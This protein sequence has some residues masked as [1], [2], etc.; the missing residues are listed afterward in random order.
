MKK[1]QIENIISYLKQQEKN[2]EELKIG[3]EFEY[4][5]VDENTLESISYYGETGIES[6][7]QALLSKN[8]QGVYED[9]HLIGLKIRN[10]T[11]TLEPGSQIEISLESF[12]DI[13]RLEEEYKLI[14]QDL[15]EIFG[16]KNKY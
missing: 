4:F 11:I 5:V 12:N 10:S 9:E 6:S 8:Y 7:L 16:K 3:A 1:G 13:S 2:K 14:C 15:L